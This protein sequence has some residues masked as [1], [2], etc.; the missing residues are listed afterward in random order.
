MLHT[1][2]TS[3]NKF[4]FL[5]RS[6]AWF[7]DIFLHC[8][9]LV[10]ALIVDLPVYIFILPPLVRSFVLKHKMFDLNICNFFS[11]KKGQIYHSEL[12]LFGQVHCGIILLYNER[13]IYI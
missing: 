12:C 5:R 8:F 3:W 1:C 6:F 7:L 13:Y 9:D 10:F 11:A 4:L 2:K